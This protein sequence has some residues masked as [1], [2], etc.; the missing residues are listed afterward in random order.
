MTGVPTLTYLSWNGNDPDPDDTVTY[1]VLFGTSSPPTSLL[2][3]DTPATTCNP[4]T[5][6]PNTTYYWQVTATDNHG[7]STSGEEW[8]FTTGN[9]PPLKPNNPAPADNAIDVS[10]NIEISWVGGDSNPGDTVTYDVMFGT[11]SPPITQLR[12][13][14]TATSFNPGLLTNNTTY[15]WQVTATDNHGASTAGEEW[16]FTTGNNPPIRP[17]DPTPDDKATD[18]SINTDLTWISGDPDQDD[19]VTYDVFFGTSSPPIT[20]L[21]DDEVATTCDPGTLNDSTTYYWQV[22]TTDNH[23][24]STEGNV[25]QFITDPGDDQPMRIFLPLLNR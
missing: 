24:A 19:T 18:V 13:D 23:G 22:I 8:E 15:Y 6:S 5:L 11:T 4:G 25:W 1:D 12:D 10:I 16:K 3:D 21:C 14:T 17:E 20:L 9:N 2:C 7:A